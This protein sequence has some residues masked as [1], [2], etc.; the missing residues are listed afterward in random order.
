MCLKDEVN[1]A[2]MRTFTFTRLPFILL[3]L[4]QTIVCAQSAE[5]SNA[6]RVGINRAFFGSGD[7]V[8]PA[9]YAEYSYQLNPYLG[10][11]P[12][13]ISGV[14]SRVLP[15]H[16]DHVSSFAANL[17]VRVTPL[18]NYLRWF[19]IDIGGLYHRFTNTYGNTGPPFNGQPTSEDAYHYTENLWGFVGAI[20]TDFVNRETFTLGA[21][22][23]LLTSLSEG[24]LNADSWQIGLYYS[25]KF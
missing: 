24:Y 11:A 17:S 25:R 12:R 8:G 9:L 3:L 6:V 23:E 14:A 7:V 20:N 4:T 15:S 18:P 19:S 5:P 2:L 1:I 13:L 10:I 16:F 22:L 21:R